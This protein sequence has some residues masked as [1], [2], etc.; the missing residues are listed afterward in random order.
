MSIGEF[1]LCLC[2]LGNGLQHLVN[3]ELVCN[4]YVNGKE[5]C[6]VCIDGKMGCDYCANVEM[7]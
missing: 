3:G 4:I 6:D 1:L 5:V 7:V 2:Q